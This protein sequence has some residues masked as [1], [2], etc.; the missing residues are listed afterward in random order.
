[1]PTLA[2][3]IP[4]ELHEKPYLKDFLTMEQTPESFAKVFGKLD[5]A[6][7]LI[8]K[9]TTGIPAADAKDDEVEGFFAKMRPAKPEDYE[10]L[11]KDPKKADPKFLQGLREAFHAA[12]ADKRQV[13]KFMARMNTTLGEYEAEAVKQATAHSEKQKASDAEFTK[14]V[15]ETFGEK[16]KETLARSRAV[17]KEVCPPNLAAHIEKLDNPS[18]AIVNG[19]IAG[20]L[21]RFGAED[22]F[23]PHGEGQAGG[24]DDLVKL[25]EEG[26][27][28]LASPEYRDEFHTGHEAA[29]KR[30]GEIYAILGAAKEK[31]GKK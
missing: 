13:A 14:L 29:K 1:M 26:R 19:I 17:L 7:T 5:G 6:E 25:Q 11:V 18:L 4:K 3:V 27:K 28:L 15:E 30:V 16:S 12:G 24:G 21:K 31:A 10:I 20:L 2:E 22:K 8:G 9:R 23:N